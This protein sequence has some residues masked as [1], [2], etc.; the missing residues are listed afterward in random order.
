MEYKI[1]DIIQVGYWDDLTSEFDV[2]DNGF[3]LEKQDIRMLAPDY[4]YLCGNFF[5]VI[6]TDDFLESVLIVDENG[7]RLWV[8]NGIVRGA[9]CFD[10]RFDFDDDEIVSFLGDVNII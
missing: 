7:R 6:D 10:D 1:G 2:D 9:S 8:H 5:A 3:L 4:K